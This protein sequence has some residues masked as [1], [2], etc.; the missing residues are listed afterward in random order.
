MTT[1][2]QAMI[3]A[4]LRP[5]DIIADGAWRR[6]ATDDKPAKKNGAYKLSVGGGSGWFRN[7]ATHDEL[8]VWDDGRE[9]EVKPMDQARLQA[10]RDKE[11][12]YRIQAM[13]SARAFWDRAR[14]L[15]RPHPYIVRKGLSPLGCAGLRTHDGVMVVPVML[16]DWLVSVQTITPDG[17]KRFWPGAP[18]KGGAYVMSRPRAAVTCVCEG[19]ATGLA[20][21]QSVRQASVVVAFDAGNLLPVVQRLRPTG[22]VVLCA[23]NDH[24]TWARINTN[25]G[26]EKARNAA[27]LLGAGVAYP[28]GIE[29]SDW[30]DA[31]KEWGEG[32]ARRIER[33]ILQGARYVATPS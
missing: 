28:Q 2:Q 11:R 15:N 25:P 3:G 19:L 6:C 13:K 17:E 14:P 29:G 18:V 26:L 1:F 16:G 7:W 8:C 5:R 23:D 20:V 30:A 12:A 32:A 33:E 22:S 21:Y 4:G 10:S 24:K 9:H 31:L 27:E